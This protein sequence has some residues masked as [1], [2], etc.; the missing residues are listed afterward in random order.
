VNAQ[1]LD[2]WEDEPEPAPPSDTPLLD[3]A[4]RYA[5]HGIHVFPAIIRR[6]EDGTKDVNPVGPWREMSTTDP[7]RIRMWFGLNGMYRSAALC[8]D[9]GKS[10]LVGVDSDGE[11]GNTNWAAFR[12]KHNLGATWIAHTPGGGQHWYYRAD[13]ERPV[14][15]TRGTTARGIAENV[16][17]RGAGGFLIAPPTR[18]YRGAYRWGAEGEPEW[19]EL[20]VVPVPVV[21]AVN[22]KRVGRPSKPTRP[23]RNAPPPPS[24][25]EIRQAL[26]DSG[27]DGFINED[28]L[29]RAIGARR[30]TQEQAIG[31]CKPHMARLRAAKEGTRN[32]SLNTAAKALSHFVPAFWSR[33]QAESYLYKALDPAY[34]Q[35]EA[36]RTVESAFGSA[37]G[38]W[39][40]E[41]IEPS[42]QQA[43]DP[44][45][46]TRETGEADRAILP[47]LPDEFWNARSVLR[48][49]RQAAWARVQVPD[50]VFYACLVRM[51]AL[52][53]YRIKANSG[54]S[55]AASL[56]LYAAVIGSSGDG[57]S[58]GIK[59]AKELIHDPPGVDF[60]GTLPLGSGEG[61]AEAYQG[62]VE[63][64]G[65]NGKTLKVKEQVRHNVL[66]YVDEGQMLI[67]YLFARNGATT[68]AALRSAWGGEMI[69]QKNAVEETTRIVREGTYAFGLIVAMQPSVVV[70]LLADGGTGMPQR[71]LWS[72]ATDPTIPDERVEWPGQLP[73]DPQV[74]RKPTTIHLADTIKDELFRASIA[75]KRGEPDAQL[76]DLD[77]QSPL[78]LV[79]LAA[80]LA[81]LDSRTDVTVEDW[82]LAHLVWDTS[83]KVRTV[84][85]QHSAE[86]KR[87]TEEARS[88]LYIERKVRETIE[89]SAVPQH[90]ERIAKLVARWVHASTDGVSRDDMRKVR[91]AGRD[92]KYLDSAIGH[93][94][95]QKWVRLHGGVYVKD[96]GLAAVD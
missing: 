40:A 12:T 88:E 32:D 25:D 39:V 81:L 38:D 52:L 27:L 22:G 66:M 29:D 6:G 77:G 73:W 10:D 96:R 20:P 67:K 3:A 61:V 18:D 48:H 4:L 37:A 30:F 80:L 19:P 24:K 14:K 15:N 49:I 95:A 1:S 86:Q 57:K 82:D 74:I 21:D 43:G 26:A 75:R 90:I 54:I 9:T 5:E 16:D 64:E 31:F 13:P 34:P 59:V 23:D 76:A 83:C 93:A 58:Q 55:G 42:A 85:V 17:T 91:C 70:Q 7:M 45:D 65:D 8:I 94:V 79:K 78:M 11:L 44:G 56:N 41:K 60:E 53:D 36:A 72:T 2:L 50:V 92:K 35:D 51:S 89:V 71:F 28:D 46:P 33:A 47:G 63:K 62:M 84:L 68:G 69:G 87:R